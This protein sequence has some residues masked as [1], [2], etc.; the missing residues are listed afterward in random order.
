V[1]GVGRSIAGIGREGGRVSEPTE[2][3]IENYHTER[4]F[5]LRPRIDIPRLS[6]EMEAAHARG[7]SVHLWD[8][9]GTFQIIPRRGERG[10][11]IASNN[12]SNGGP[13]RLDGSRMFFATAAEMLLMLEHLLGLDER[14][15]NFG[16]LIVSVSAHK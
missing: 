12:T 5:S 6:Q 16:Y 9:Y 1:A 10:A 3:R 13:W 8:S 11:H 15:E 2:V 7:D 4:G 14:D